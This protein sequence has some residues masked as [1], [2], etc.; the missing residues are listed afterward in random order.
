[1]QVHANKCAIVHSFSCLGCD[2]FK[3]H[4]NK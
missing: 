4:S 1:L 2:F 3:S